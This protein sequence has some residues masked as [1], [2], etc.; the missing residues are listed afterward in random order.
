MKSGQ[1][2]IKLV[3]LLAMQIF[4]E[5]C[6]RI[7]SIFIIPILI[8]KL[9][10]AEY[11]KYAVLLTLVSLVSAAAS[12]GIRESLLRFN[13]DQSN[14]EGVNSNF[15]RSLY[16]TVAV[17]S[18]TSITILTC[19][20]SLSDNIN[21]EL[22]GYIFAYGLLVELVAVI[23]THLRAIG[24]FRFYYYLNFLDIVLNFIFILLA[25]RQS[26]FGIRLILVAMV[27]SS[28]LVLTLGVVLL[29]RS[30][31]RF[32]PISFI[33]KDMFRFASPLALN[34]VLMWITNGADKLILS[35]MTSS[36]TLGQ[37]SLAYTVGLMS[38]SVIASGV[39]MMAPRVLFNSNQSIWQA[40]EIKFAT[41]A[42]GLLTISTFCFV[43]ILKFNQKI[44]EKYLPPLNWRDFLAVSFIVA[45]SYLCLYLGDHLR[46]ILFHQRITRYEPFILGFSAFLNI[47]LNL[48]LIP[49]YGI[50]GA[51]WS[52]F[53]SISIQP[54][55]ILLILRIKNLRIRILENFLV[56][57]AVLISIFSLIF[58][59]TNSIVVMLFL[60]ISVSFFLYSFSSNSFNI[61]L[62]LK[63]LRLIRKEKS[64][65][66][67]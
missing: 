47:V 57:N 63:L 62:K 42:M 65:D 14:S 7:K 27:V 61:N 45:I 18:A 26:N 19:Y 36:E 17:Y 58:W 37:Y 66:C 24:K 44:I 52:T 35:E 20:F 9:G 31:T 4:M 55:L 53:F 46:Y 60:L 34:G 3:K 23:N 59:N 64:Y 48:I 5:F 56:L 2:K 22:L 21:A 33:S 25:T 54:I 38:V 1:L 10:F 30:G 13:S 29:K 39:F 16:T 50:Q 11:G 51:A 15:C 6:L 49:N 12:F 40:R 8:T 32:T 28:S 43:T 67:L 41:R